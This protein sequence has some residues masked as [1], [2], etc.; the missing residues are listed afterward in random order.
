M[1]HFWSRR[2]GLALHIMEG[3]TF[4]I[5]KKHV[6]GDVL[7]V[8]KNIPGRVQTFLADKHCNKRKTFLLK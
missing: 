2:T 5:V 8:R 7:V 6:W 4:F 3:K 1:E